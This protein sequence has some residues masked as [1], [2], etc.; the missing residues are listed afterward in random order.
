MLFVIEPEPYQLALEQA[1]SR[2]SSADAAAKQSQ[3]DYKRAAELVA[4]GSPRS[5]ISTRRRPSATPTPPSRSRRRPTSS[6]PQLNLS[7][8]QVKAPFDGIVTARQVSMGQLVGAGTTTLATIVQ[9]DPIYVNFN[10]SEQDVL[11]VRADMAKRGMTAAGSEEDTGRGRPAD[12]DRL[13]AQGHARLCGARRH[14]RPPARCGARRAAQRRPPAAA[15]LFRARARAARRRAG[16]AA[17]SRPRHR[18]RPERALSCWSPART[19]S[20]SS[21]RSRSASWSAS[22][23]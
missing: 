10:V 8:T 7:Y 19:T 5:R 23:G 21:A 13:S 3:A 9:L 20:S 15:R 16:H 12:R 1:Q 11:R 18:Q 6:R 17:R 22:C 4:K 2:Q 14:R